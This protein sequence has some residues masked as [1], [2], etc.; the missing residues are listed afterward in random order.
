MKLKFKRKQ[1]YKKFI[2]ESALI[3]GAASGLGKELAIIYSKTLKNIYLI[4][5]N[6][7]GLLN[8]KAEIESATNCTVSIYCMDLSNLRE[9]AILA[10]ALPPVD[11]LINCAAILLR[12]SICNTPI[13]IYK[14]A[15]AVNYYSSVLL[16]T[17]F[18]NKQKPPKK[19][20]DILSTSAITGIKNM[21]VYSAT[22]A[23]LWSF[24]RSLRRVYG[25]KIQ[26]IEVIPSHFAS[27]LFENCLR[28]DGSSTCNLVQSGYKGS[29]DISRIIYVKEKGGEDIIFDS[30]KSK[31]YLLTNLLFPALS[32]QTIFTRLTE[33]DPK[34]WTSY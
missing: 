30:F 28:S 15:F 27:S 22:K 10:E 29:T 13:D 25:N 5:R 18:I 31:L 8:V 19:I 33:A 26:I 2:I 16:I 20:I 1:N 3:T 32:R 14:K 9:V 4:D 24:T 12:S 7:E 11:L 34:N 21:G 17:K 23:S 6:Q